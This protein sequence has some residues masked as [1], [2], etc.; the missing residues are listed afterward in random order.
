[1]ASIQAKSINEVITILDDII[2]ECETNNDPAGYFAALYRKVTLKVKEGIASNLFDDG[3][4]MEQLDVLFANRYID[5]YYSYQNGQDVTLS[6]LRAFELT[7]QYWPIVLQHLLMGMNAHI[8]LDLG[9]AAAEVSKGKDINDL[10]GDFDKINDVLASLVADV[11]K[12]LSDIWP[13]LKKILK[14]TQ[15]VDDFLI[16]FSMEIARDKAW[17]FAKSLVGQNE[18]ETKTLI[19][20]RDEKIAGNARIITNPGFIAKTLFIIIRLGERG[21]VASKIEELK[22]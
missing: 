4:R 17:E 13:T 2:A 9:I 14:L 20:I 8:G 21:T 18:T 10:K 15:K 16:T 3:F 1:M 5:A 22:S 7:K 12:D 11:E 19:Q 6:Y